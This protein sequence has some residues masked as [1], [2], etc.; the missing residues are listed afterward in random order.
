MGKHGLAKDCFANGH[1][2]KPADKFS[3][4]PGFD[5][6]CVASPIQVAVGLDHIGKNPCARLPVSSCFCTCSDDLIKAAIKAYFYV[7]SHPVFGNCLF[8]RAMQAKLRNMKRHAR[9]R[10]PPQWWLPLAEP[11]IDSAAVSVKQCVCIQRSPRA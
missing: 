7:P 4:K 6:V 1:A 3:A 5:G 8:Q 2:V 9:V 11:W 10:T